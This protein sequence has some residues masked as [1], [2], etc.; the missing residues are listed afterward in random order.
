MSAHRFGRAFDILFKNYTSEQIRDEIRN[1]PLR[2]EFQFIT[3]IEDDVSWLHIDCR[4]SKYDDVR[5][6]K[7]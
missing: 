4:N 2:E 3:Y 7:G 5:F 1:M 6:F